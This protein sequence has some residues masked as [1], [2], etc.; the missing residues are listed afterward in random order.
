MMADSKSSSTASDAASF[1]GARPTVQPQPLLPLAV[2]GV[3]PATGACWQ[4]LLAQVAVMHWSATQSLSAMQQ[5]TTVSTPQMCEP[6][7]HLPI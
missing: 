6:T 2:P 1:A 4:L 3:Q 7:A 5:P